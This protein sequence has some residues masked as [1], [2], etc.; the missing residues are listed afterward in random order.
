MEDR[1]PYTV[2]QLVARGVSPARVKELLAQGRLTRVAPRWLA[3]VSTPPEAIRAVQLGGRLG[4]LSAC[5]HHGLWVPRDPDLHIA[6]NP[7]TPVPAGPPPG[8]RFHRLATSCPRAVLPLEEAVT[9]VVHRHDVE[10]GLVVLESAVNSGL[11][12]QEEARHLL[13]RLPTRKAAAAQHFSH[14]AES[15]SETRLRLFFQRH[16]VPVQPQVFVP[17]LGRVDLLVGRSWIVEAD[18]TAH[19]SAPQDVRRDRDR[20]MNSRLTGYDRDRLSYEQIWHSWAQTQEFLLAR[21]REKRHLRPPRPLNDI[22]V[23]RP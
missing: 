11:M 17:G 1:G 12:H 9:Q 3:D 10:T 16:R 19:H 18:S 8:V 23:V 13:D 5:R 15:G 7:G 21:I 4:C 22:A 14:L 20:D 2:A 6:L